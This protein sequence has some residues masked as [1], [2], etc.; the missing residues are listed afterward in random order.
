MC[1]LPRPIW[2]A[3]SS[4]W[5]IPR[6]VPSPVCVAIW[7]RRSPDLNA[8]LWNLAL[9]SERRGEL[10]DPT[11]VNDDVIVVNRS[12]TRIILKDSVL[13]DVLDAVNPFSPLAR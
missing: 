12:R 1:I 2:S 5:E 6:R 3:S 9:V 4:R 13:R 8:A 11:V 10:E 7:N